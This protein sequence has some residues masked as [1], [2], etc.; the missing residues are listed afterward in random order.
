[1]NLNRL[2]TVL[3]LNIALIISQGCSTKNEFGVLPTAQQDF[4]LEKETLIKKFPEI[5]AYEPGFR[6]ISCS[7]V[8]HLEKIWGKPDEIQTDWVQVPLLIVPIALIDGFTTGG[9]IATGMVYGM[10]PKQPR[11]YIWKK[12]RYSI[13]AYVNASVFCDYKNA[14]GYWD[15]VEVAK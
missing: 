7:E 15:W 1:V 6:K 11:H 4:L 12:G 10:M 13:D 14:V 2:L 9:L 5:R 8:E 3:I